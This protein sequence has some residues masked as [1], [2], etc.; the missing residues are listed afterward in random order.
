VEIAGVVGHAV[1]ITSMLLEQRAHRLTVDVPREGLLW[2]GD[3]VRLAQVVANLLTNAARYTPHGGDIRMFCR[4]EG[5]ELVLN[6]RDNG[7]GIP[8]ELLPRVFDLFTQGKRNVD[9][10][11]GGL[12]LG[13]TL[14]KTLVALHGGSVSAHSDG[15]GKGSEFIIRLPLAPIDGAPLARSTPAFD[16]RLSLSPSRR[17][18][19]VDDNADAADLLAE[20]L[21]ISGYD[22]QVAND[23]VHALEKA[24]RFLPEI[25]ILDIGLPVMDGYEL[26]ERLRAQSELESCRFIALT[27]YGQERDRSRSRA[28]DFANHFVK[29]VDVEQLMAAIT[30]LLPG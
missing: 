16:Q 29:P 21:R 5:T 7:A 24:Q 19:L 26:A 2:E 6:V 10:A 30:D 17:I 22:V 1:E 18:L 25:A 4:R 14:V 11:G 28:H 13:L 9:R 8:A 27:G 20:A 23:P 15:P 12:G 3:P